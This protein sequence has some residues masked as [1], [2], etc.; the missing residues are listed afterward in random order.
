MS[1]SFIFVLESNSQDFSNGNGL[2]VSTKGHET[3]IMKQMGLLKFRYCNPEREWEPI[4]TS[5]TN[6]V[7][8][9]ARV[10][11]HVLKQLHFHP[12]FFWSNSKCTASKVKMTR[13]T[14]EASTLLLSDRRGDG[15]TFLVNFWCDFSVTSLFNPWL[16][17]K[18]FSKMISPS[19]NKTPQPLQIW[20]TQWPAHIFSLGWSQVLCIWLVVPKS[21]KSFQLTQPPPRLKMPKLKILAQKNLVKAEPIPSIYGVFTYIWWIFMVNGRG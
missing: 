11:Q 20:A 8:T 10:S 4:L 12:G 9:N 15:L 13:A 21:P 3:H 14:E 18:V 19:F 5:T 16:F 1:S 7:M 6:I 17:P 2:P